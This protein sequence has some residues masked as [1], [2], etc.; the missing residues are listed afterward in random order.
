VKQVVIK[1]SDHM[2]P[3]SKP[4]DV[5]SAAGGWLG[6]QMRRWNEEAEEYEKWVKL[7]NEQKRT[8]EQYWGTWMERHYDKKRSRYRSQGCYSSSDAAESNAHL[9]SP[10]FHLSSRFIVRNVL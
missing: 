6:L 7:P 5:A 9:A 8:T 10:K 3:F 1:D 2:V 4:W